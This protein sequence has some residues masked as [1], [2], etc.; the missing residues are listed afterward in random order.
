[1]KFISVF[2]AFALLASAE[3][4]FEQ[5]Q[6]HISEFTLKNGLKFIILERHQAPVASF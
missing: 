4:S 3:N 1:M 6:S 2:A 5:V